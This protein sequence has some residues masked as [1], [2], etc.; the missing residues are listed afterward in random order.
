MVFRFGGWD[1]C[2]RLG[3]FRIRGVVRSR[4]IIF[5]KVVVG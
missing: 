2:S 4:G 5:F 1:F 3:G